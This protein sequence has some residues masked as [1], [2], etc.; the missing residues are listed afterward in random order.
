MYK[1]WSSY[2][3]VVPYHTLPPEQRHTSV[4]HEC[5]D[6]HQYPHTADVH[7]VMNVMNV[8]VVCEIENPR[9]SDV[10]KLCYQ[11]WGDIVVGG[12]G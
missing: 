11:V 4:P 8:K 2:A 10:D 6:L 12:G 1:K 7:C 9:L 3:V 5:V